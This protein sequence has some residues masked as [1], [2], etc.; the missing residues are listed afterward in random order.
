ML[1]PLRARGTRG[2]GDG[3][4]THPDVHTARRRRSVSASLRLDGRGTTPEKR[5][6]LDKPR[7]SKD[8]PTDVYE[9][10]VGEDTVVRLALPPL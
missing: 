6:R 1:F 5:R 10:E 7:W 9:D 4:Y 3:V 2:T 8:R